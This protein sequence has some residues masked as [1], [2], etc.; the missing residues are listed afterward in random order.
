M[1]KEA[2]KASSSATPATAA[3]A[4]AT[5]SGTAAASA[6]PAGTTTASQPTPAG[7]SS[8]EKLS[9]NDASAAPTSGSPA[10]AAAG[11]SSTGS[12]LHKHDSGSTSA[13]S[14]PA[15]KPGK[16]TPEQRKQLAELDELKAKERAER[17]TMLVRELLDRVRPFV[18]ATRPGDPSDPETQAFEKRIKLEAEDLKVRRASR[19]DS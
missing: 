11:G 15:A 2:E 9:M 8:I 7:L 4:A 16:L 3:A 19:S 10:P 5:S 6:P 13:A 14:K 17:V 12:E 18:H 1:E